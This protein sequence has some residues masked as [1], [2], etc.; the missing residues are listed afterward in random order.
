[1]KQLF[2]SAIVLAGLLS[3]SSCKKN[4]QDVPAPVNDVKLGYEQAKKFFENNAPKYE[5]FTVDASAGGTITTSKGTK[6]NFPGG[7]FKNGAGQT[8]SGNVTVQVKDILSASDMLLGNRPTDAGGKMLV[9]FGEM[10]VKASQNGQDLQLRNDSARVQVPLAPNPAAGQQMREIPMWSGDSAV[11]YTINGNNE[12]N[13]AVTL[14]QSGYIPR[15]ISWNANGNFATNNNNGTSTF[16][17][18]SLGQWRNCD[19]LM[20]DPRPKT[21]VLG[22]FTNQWNPE[23]SASYMGS[24][25]SMLFFKVKQQ[26]TLVKL[27]NKIITSVSGKEGL[28]SYQNSFPVGMEGTFLA[29]TFKGGKVYAEMKDVTIGAPAG[30]KTYYPVSFVLNEI[31]E[32]QLLSLIQQLN[33]K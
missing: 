12:E 23:T 24:E 25:P 1:M 20:S 18:D 21:T 10:T 26:N 13:L 6:I 2:F 15:G 19:A 17:L 9:S 11:T 22:Y 28:L 30:G 31:T 14:Q 3:F 16:N 33:T 5:S 29:I 27:Y 7:I 8:V 4:R 32:A